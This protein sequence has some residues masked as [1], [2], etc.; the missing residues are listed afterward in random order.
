MKILK[1]EMDQFKSADC[2]AGHVPARTSNGKECDQL[3]VGDYSPPAQAVGN[4]PI[5]LEQAVASLP[6][7]ADSSAPIQ[8]LIGKGGGV[9]AAEVPAVV[10]ETQQS[11][12]EEDEEEDASSLSGPI[13]PEQC[14]ASGPG[15]T[16][17]TAGSLVSF[18]VHTKDT[19]G[20][21]LQEG[22]A[23][24]VVK[25][26]HQSKTP[27][28]NSVP[29]E[30][31]IV[32]NGNGSYKVSYSVLEKGS[33][34]V[35]IKINGASITG[36]PFP[37]YF[38]APMPG[39]IPPESARSV[40]AACNINTLAAGGGAGAGVEIHTAQQVQAYNAMLQQ[41][42]SLAQQV[43][44]LRTA[45]ISQ[46]NTNVSASAVAVAVAAASA[47]RLATGAAGGR[48]AEKKD[49]R[50][51]DRSRSPG[52]RNKHHHPHG[53]SKD[54]R[55]RRSRSRS[56]ERKRDHDPHRS[57]RHLSSNREKDA[58]G[59]GD[60]QGHS[61]HLRHHSRSRDIKNDSPRRVEGKAAKKIKSSEQM[62]M[63]A[64]SLQKETQQPVSGDELEDLLKE[65]EDA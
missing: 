21:F 17:G 1:L 31:Q 6:F 32:E 37:V 29:I 51:R 52:R 27:N 5:I 54:P 65:L 25:I 44:E 36:S 13:D 28:Q 14:I 60:R 50:H 63:L 58:D 35:D 2:A 8:D 24:I 12:D 23:Y 43:A 16:G 56:R 61:S 22:G 49:F 47:W 20:R 4:A 39:E 30:A 18:L 55:R 7:F 46:S 41:Q 10:G 34:Q 42:T 45:H 59:N 57:H 48:A 11:S 9:I 62:M 38:S 26:E 33:Y 15:I 64:P 53:S 40:A 3:H 19:S